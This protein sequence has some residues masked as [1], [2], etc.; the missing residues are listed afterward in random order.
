MEKEEKNRNKSVLTYSPKRRWTYWKK[1]QTVPA[2]KIINYL[3]LKGQYRK[4]FHAHDLRTSQDQQWV[5]NPESWRP[6]DPS[7]GSQLT[8]IQGWRSNTLCLSFLVYKGANNSSSAR[9][10]QLLGTPKEGALRGTL[11]HLRWGP[12][13]SSRITWIFAKAHSMG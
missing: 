12:K 11:K 9:Y 1:S 8:Y 6:G 5:N 10:L 3:S 13:I 4:L 2:L 7:S